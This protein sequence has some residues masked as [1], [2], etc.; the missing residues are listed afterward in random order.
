MKG[1]YPKIGA[2]HRFSGKFTLLLIMTET[3][4]ERNIMS[5][6][7][8]FLEL[9]FEGMSNFYCN[10]AQFSQFFVTKCVYFN[11]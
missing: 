6:D 1:A 2:Q 5:G 11:K 4:I 9:P 3:K 8:V 10:Y 7:F